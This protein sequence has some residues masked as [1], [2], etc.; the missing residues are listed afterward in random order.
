M[1]SLPILSTACFPPISYLAIIAQST[2]AFI[3]PFENYSKQSFRN[4]Y[5]IY[6]PNGRQTLSI[7]IIKKSGQKT[8]L[9][10][11]K[12]EF[13]TEWKKV[14]L[15]SLTA[16]YANTPFFEYY[17][18]EVKELILCHKE[19]LIDYNQMI[20]NGLQKL[21]N[22]NI[23]IHFTEKFI[24]TGSA[25]LDYREAFHPKQQ[26]RKPLIKFNQEPYYQIFS[27]K[28]GFM[29]DLSCLDLLFHKGPEAESFLLHQC[30]F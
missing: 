3:D 28:F 6:S 18:P 11:T 21:F 13:V 1:N 24:E 10:D 9:R 30:N 5:E 27:D 23:A 12:I 26:R 4:R 25:A 20:L 7:P 19:Y 2:G 8:L 16:A 14:H 17:F 29:E 22:L 15:R